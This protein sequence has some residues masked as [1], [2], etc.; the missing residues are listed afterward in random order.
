MTWSAMKA[1]VNVGVSADTA[2]FAVCSIE[3]WWQ[4]MGSGAYP[5]ASSLTIV[6]D[7]GGS[8]AA[9]SRLWKVELQ[10][11]SNRTGL[12]INVC[13]FPPGTSKWNK[14]E[15]RFFSFISHNWRG[16][17]LID[18]ATIISLITNTT[19]STGLVA[20]ARLDSNLEFR[21]FWRVQGPAAGPAEI[22]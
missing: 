1:H 21:H 8:N 18:Y 14:I 4:Q 3:A 9:R 5:A 6:A 7:S 11:F 13:H 16:K 2:Q 22:A 10:E 19:T 17:P 15:H 20:K 12:E